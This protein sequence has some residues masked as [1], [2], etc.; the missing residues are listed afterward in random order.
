MYLQLRGA[1][2]M[3]DADDRTGHVVAEVVNHV[4][5]VA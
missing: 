1:S 3:S 2:T 4:Q 5:E